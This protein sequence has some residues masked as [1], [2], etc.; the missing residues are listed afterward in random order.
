MTDYTVSI[1]VTDG[2]ASVQIVDAD[3][4]LTHEQTD[5]TVP[6]AMDYLTRTIAELE[7]H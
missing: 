5:L 2:Y 4:N 1:Y 7:G 6:E 3:D